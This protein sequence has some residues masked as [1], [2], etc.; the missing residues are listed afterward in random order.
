MSF[1][2]VSTEGNS[3]VKSARK[4]KGNEI[5]A[6]AA[7]PVARADLRNVDNLLLMSIHPR[8]CL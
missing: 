4:E 6:I 1:S 2:S 8:L 3:F 5:K 7:S